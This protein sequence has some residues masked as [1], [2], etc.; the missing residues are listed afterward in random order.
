M[1]QKNKSFCIIETTQ[2]CDIYHIKFGGLNNVF[3][4]KNLKNISNFF[5]I[6]NV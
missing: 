1:S 4:R 2:C 3:F 6:P 5:C